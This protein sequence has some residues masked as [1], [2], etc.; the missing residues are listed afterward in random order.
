MIHKLT[1]IVLIVLVLGGHVELGRQAEAG[2]MYA[3]SLMDWRDQP[4][5]IRIGE[6]EF[7]LIDASEVAFAQNPGVLIQVHDDFR[8]RI[9]FEFEGDSRNGPINGWV[10]YSVVVLRP[11]GYFVDGELNSSTAGLDVEVRMEVYRPP[12]TWPFEM[13]TSVDGSTGFVYL[14][15]IREGVFRNEWLINADSAL[16]SFETTIIQGS[17]EPP[18]HWMICGFVALALASRLH[19]HSTRVMGVGVSADRG[20][21]S[22][23]PIDSLR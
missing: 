3:G 13:T 2:T 22:R 10:Q 16:E 4:N 7:T 9:A 23:L 1:Q 6:D 18:G 8:Y 19:R 21:S 5:P 17:P 20:P 15:G 14:L 12:F 11:D